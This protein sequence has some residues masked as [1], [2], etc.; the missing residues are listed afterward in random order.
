MLAALAGGSLGRALA[1]RDSDPDMKAQ[2]DAALAMLLPALERKPDQ[3]W[4][5]VQ[6]ATGFGKAGR[7]KLRLALEFHQ[8]WLRDVLR[9][10]YGGSEESLVNRDRVAELRKLAAGLD[11]AEVRRRLLVLEEALRSIDG[12]VSADLTLFSTLSRVAGDRVG[13]GA[14]PA[15]AAARWDI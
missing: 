6:G 15:H 9:L 1:M 12:N 10:R 2:R 4:R 11:A 8:L 5:L 3:L 7:E 14:W 13:E